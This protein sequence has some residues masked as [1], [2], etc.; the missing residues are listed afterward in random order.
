MAMIKCP[1]CDKEISDKAKKCVHC[2][3]ILVE[4]EKI[5]CE[6]CGYELKKNAKVCP[7]C[8]CPVE[9][10]T[11]EKSVEK[12][13][14]DNHIHDD[15]KIR[16]TYCGSDNVQVQIVSQNKN[17]GCLTVFL[18]ILLALTIVG[19][20]IMIII[21]L[22]KG[23]KTVNKKFYVCQ[24]CGKT[25]S[26]AVVGGIKNTSAGQVIGIIIAVLFGI[27]ILS[28]IINSF[29]SSSN[30]SY[31]I[32][33]GE[34]VTKEKYKLNEE[35]YCMGEVI[36]VKSVNY[37][38]KIDNKWIPDAGEKFIEINVVLKNAMEN[39]NKT[40][41]VSDFKLVTSSGIIVSP[42]DASEAKGTIKSSTE[43]TPGGAASG[44]IVFS[45]PKNDTKTTLRYSCGIW[46][47][48]SKI[49]IDTSKK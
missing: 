20:P 39:S 21:L 27:A 16:C 17:A 15:K 32:E 24:N 2:G 47:S 5:I 29:G 35:I 3:E 23:K 48:E 9:T 25:F 22:V 10:K 44:K 37:S 45:I 1:K 38:S 34:Q 49:E 31:V 28:G 19:I 33:N 6:E 13:N 26:P 42:K 41:Y 7:K 11:G 40:F 8:G 46:P 43:V 4:E 12:S 18:Y 30:S 36:T 14:E